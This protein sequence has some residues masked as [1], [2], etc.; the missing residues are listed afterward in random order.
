MTVARPVHKIFKKGDVEHRQYMLG[1]GIFDDP[2]V[3][4]HAVYGDYVIVGRHG[5]NQRTLY[6]MLERKI[7][8]GK[9]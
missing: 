4:S 5:T 9:V 8:Q 6:K 7:R 3:V 1:L 2:Q